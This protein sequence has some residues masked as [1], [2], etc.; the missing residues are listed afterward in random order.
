MERSPL[1]AI[2]RLL[3]TQSTLTL[4]T[5]DG[6]G[7]PHAAPLFYVYGDGPRLF[8]LSDP[9]SQHSRNLKRDP[10][11]A[12]SVYRETAD[13]RKIRGVQLRGSVSII[14]DPAS[15]EK[16]LDTYKR[17]FQLSAR[18][19]AAILRCTLY[20]FEPAWVRYLDNSKRFGYSVEAL[21][22]AAT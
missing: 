5:A 3:K 20:C 22:P 10:R 15:R 16:L 12:V 14:A 9:R 19:E 13:W 17:R 7:A 8:W 4:S 1:Q 21:V 2:A 11:A 18:F 6:K